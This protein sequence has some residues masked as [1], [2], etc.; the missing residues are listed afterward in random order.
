VKIK[1]IKDLSPEELKQKEKDLR[2][3]MFRLR[4]RH[5]AG[6]LESS[7]SLKNAR[8]EIARVKTVLREKEASG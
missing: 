2:E 5:A 8:K 3:E 7:A 6:Q 1:E 4:M